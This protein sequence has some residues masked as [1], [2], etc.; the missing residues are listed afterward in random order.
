MQ[1][2]NLSE[3]FGAGGGRS[4]LRAQQSVDDISIESCS[5]SPQDIAPG[6]SVTVSW[7]AT[8]TNS[9]I[10][11]APTFAI[12]ING[13]PVHTFDQ[14]RL[15]PGQQGSY[16]E[17]IT[18]GSRRGQEQEITLYVQDISYGDDGGG[19]PSL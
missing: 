8:N 12:Y 17:T 16:S 7:S 9:A 6:D 3:Q 1:G 13:D 5:V 14:T 18:L 19:L 4:G 2:A 11:L 10:A 15:Q